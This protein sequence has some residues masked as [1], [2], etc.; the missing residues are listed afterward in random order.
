MQLELLFKTFLSH[1][2]NKPNYHCSYKEQ[3]RSIRH[4]FHHTYIS[5]ISSVG[6][7]PSSRYRLGPGRGYL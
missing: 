1:K 3:I 4:K 7:F 2:F 5:V 6:F